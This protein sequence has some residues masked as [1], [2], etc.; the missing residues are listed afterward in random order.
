MKLAGSTILITGG[1]SG[2]G[3][4]LAEMLHARGNA[5]IVAGRHAETLT[6]VADANPG[7]ETL[8][9]DVSDRA[10]IATAA[11][12]IL[13]RH[14]NLNVLINNAAVM[15]DDD[16][17][18]PIDDETL[19]RVVST[20]LLGPIR[21]ISAFIEH[22][23]ATPDAAIVNVT[24]MLGYTPLAS[25][26]LYSATKAAMHSYTLSLRYRL[27]GTGP[28]VI[29]VAPPFT[30][31]SLQSINLTDPRAMPLDAFVAETMAAL[32]AGDAE[33]YVTLARERRDVQRADDIGHTE[34]FNSNLGWSR[35]LSRRRAR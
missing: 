15:P 8:L 24:S 16:P 12:E 6:D 27:G 13:G 18:A 31:T 5:V 34:Q 1:G 32:E 14:P 23:R 28:E 11:Q 19:T 22:L 33:A 29:E 4:G 9:L 26:S 35:S 21:M 7:V 10:S 30:R 3:R 25:S 20:N 17:A 2:I